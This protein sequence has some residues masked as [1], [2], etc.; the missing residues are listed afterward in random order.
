MAFSV[1][2]F[3]DLY[4]LLSER[5][6][7]RARL[8][9][10]IL[11]DEFVELPER[12]ARVEEQL[13]RIA[14]RLDALGERMDQLITSQ[15]LVIER[16]NRMDGRMGNIE[17]DLLE[18]RYSDNLRNWFRPHLLKPQRLYI[19]DLQELLEAQATG[20]VSE[21]EVDRVARTDL[22]VRGTQRGG[23]EQLLLAVEVSTTINPDDVVRADHAAL[24]LRRAGY[25]AKAL[26]GG[27]RATEDALEKAKELDVLID[28][29]R[30]AA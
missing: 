22:I 11:G 18:L 2:D 23:A 8:R 12:M 16:Q 9:P 29:R 17:G 5:P 13:I 4:R 15:Q 10:L 1:D 30:P 26:V 19:D 20:Q 27:Y 21:D 6:E 24:V 7:W 3:E 25:R 28:L 14:E